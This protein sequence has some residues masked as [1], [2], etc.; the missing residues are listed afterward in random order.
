[1]VVV[2]VVVA[3][4]SVARLR[5]IPDSRSVFYV[6]RPMPKSINTSTIIGV[7]YAWSVPKVYRGKQRSFASR[8][9]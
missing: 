3:A 8:L 2:V 7:F 9:S 1:V 5:N 4:V 6:V